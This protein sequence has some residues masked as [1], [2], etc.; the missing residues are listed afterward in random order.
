MRVFN[1]LIETSQKDD[2][3][4]QMKVKYNQIS[5]ETETYKNEISVLSKQ[6]ESLKQITID[7]NAQ[8]KVI[9]HDSNQVRQ[10]SEMLIKCEEEKRQLMQENN[11]SKI[12]LESIEIKLRNANLEYND[13]LNKSK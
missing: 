12:K 8:L 13:I 11:D 1:I 2:E 4:D 6:N 9:E 3:L 10:V 5:K 7:L